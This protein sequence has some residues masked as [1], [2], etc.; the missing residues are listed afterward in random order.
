MRAN[1][2]SNDGV[3]LDG[4]AILQHRPKTPI[5]QGGDHGGRQTFFNRVQKLKAM[6]DPVAIHLAAQNKA[7]AF[8]VL[9]EI[10]RNGLG[11][12]KLL[13]ET[14]ALSRSGGVFQCCQTC[15]SI[16]VDR[17]HLNSPKSSVTVDRSTRARSGN[18]SDP[19]LLTRTKRFLRR[20]VDR[21]WVGGE[22]SEL[23]SVASDGDA[24]VLYVPFAG[25]AFS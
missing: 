18:D 13:F 9:R 8:Q 14:L 21:R 17:V 16:Q 7:R 5:L 25:T 2:Q 4:F 20:G 3:D 10:G 1:V 15:R 24:G 19:R 23:N 12:R 6:H 11:S 22:I